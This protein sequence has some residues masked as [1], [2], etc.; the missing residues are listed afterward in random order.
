MLVWINT[1]VGTLGVDEG[2]IRAAEVQELQTLEAL[3]LRI[4]RDRDALLA[5]AREAAEAELAAA[6][7]EARRLI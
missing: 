4:E 7:Q 1:A 5:A 3:R 6:Q 2:V